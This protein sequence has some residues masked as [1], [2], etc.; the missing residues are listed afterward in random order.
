MLL[1]QPALQLL[2]GIICIR[3]LIRARSK[4]RKA[5]MLIC[6]VVALEVTNTVGFLCAAITFGMYIG[7][8]EGLF[9]ELG[10]LWRGFIKT[11]DELETYRGPVA[12]FINWTIKINALN[13]VSNV[14]F[15]CTG[16]LTDAMLVSSVVSYL[17]IQKTNYKTIPRYGGVGKYGSSHSSVDLTSS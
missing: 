17:R 12:Q 4:S 8:G 2:F 14:A 6:H 13:V 1:N 15:I 9:Q 7:T 11:C 3:M 10:P 5:K 16:I